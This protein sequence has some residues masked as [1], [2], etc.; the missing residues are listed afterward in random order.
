M[1]KDAS[2]F[3]ATQF[4]SDHTHNLRSTS[5]GP[6]PLIVRSTSIS[7][8]RLSRSSATPVTDP[9]SSDVLPCLIACGFSAQALIS[10]DPALMAPH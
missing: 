8:S 5:R 10:C 7:A 1:S 3:F 4:I 2:D 9:M 6:C